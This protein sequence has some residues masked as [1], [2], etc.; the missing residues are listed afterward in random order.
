MPLDT[1]A[2]RAVYA[3]RLFERAV[4]DPGPWFIEWGGLR[5]RA[6]RELDSDGAVRFTTVVPRVPAREL[7]RLA[8][9]CRDDLVSV[10][11]APTSVDA[12]GG[13]RIGW[14][15]AFSHA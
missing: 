14:Q 7:D 15:V 2:S 4:N 6:Q 9:F 8:L 13:F 5:L 1:M 10:R 12:E 3:A 11:E